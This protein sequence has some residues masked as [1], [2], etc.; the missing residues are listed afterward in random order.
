M[1]QPKK[2]Y[3]KAVDVSYEVAEQSFQAMPPMAFS[4]GS[5]YKDKN[6]KNAPKWSNGVKLIPSIKILLHETM[7]QSIHQKSHAKHL[8]EF[9]SQNCMNLTPEMIDSVALTQRAMI[10]QLLNH[11][12][13]DRTIL[14]EWYQKY[15]CVWDMLAASEKEDG[16][17][18]HDDE[19]QCLDPVPQPIELVEVLSDDESCNAIDASVLFDSS[20]T[21]L[22]AILNVKHRITGKQYHPEV[23]P[24][25]ASQDAPKYGLSVEVMARL[26]STSSSSISPNHLKQLNVQLKSKNGSKGKKTENKKGKNK[27]TKTR[28]VISKS[29]RRDQGRDQ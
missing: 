5:L 23:P 8:K 12:A 18:D 10:C 2:T 22:K 4:N 17:P 14:K 1:M 11:K 24:E 16:A 28:S 20:N 13:N 19:V 26:M 6:F 9:S 29:R 3:R 15:A 7:G 27:I 21:A 25:T